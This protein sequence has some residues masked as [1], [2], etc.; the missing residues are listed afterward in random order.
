ML[1]EM[2]FKQLHAMKFESK[3]ILKINAFTFVKQRIKLTFIFTEP[4]CITDFINKQK[5]LIRNMV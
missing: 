4:S 5:L 1:M 2:A 3:Q